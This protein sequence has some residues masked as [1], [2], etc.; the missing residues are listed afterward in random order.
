MLSVRDCLGRS[1]LSKEKIDRKS[2]TRWAVCME[3]ELGSAAE[4]SI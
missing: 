4:G 2:E 3:D 1:R